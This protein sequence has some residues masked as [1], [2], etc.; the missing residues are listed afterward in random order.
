MFPWDGQQYAHVVHSCQECEKSQDP[1]RRPQSELDFQV[2]L[3]S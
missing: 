3:W 1:M 2:G